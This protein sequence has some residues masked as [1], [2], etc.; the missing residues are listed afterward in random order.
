MRHRRGIDLIPEKGVI[1]PDRGI[2]HL[3]LVDLADDQLLGARC[4][5]C[6]H[7]QWVDRLRLAGKYGHDATL[8]E[9]QPLL[10]CT[11]CENTEGNGFRIGRAH[12]DG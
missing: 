6:D 4:S 12:R 8:D 2:G 9:L 5:K 1:S 11:K 10:K 7:N 3:R